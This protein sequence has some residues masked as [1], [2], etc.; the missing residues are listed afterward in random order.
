[1]NKRKEVV[2]EVKEIVDENDLKEESKNIDEIF[3]LITEALNSEDVVGE[4]IKVADSISMEELE[5]NTLKI[6]GANNE[7]INCY[8]DIDYISFLGP[9]EMLSKLSGDTAIIMKNNYIAWERVRET[10]LVRARICQFNSSVNGGQPFS[11]GITFPGSIKKMKCTSK[12]ICKA[13]I[14]AIPEGKTPINPL[15]SGT[16]EE[17]ELKEE[18]SRVYQVADVYSYI[19]RFI[20]CFNDL[21]RELHAEEEE[22]EEENDDDDEKIIGGEI[23]KLSKFEFSLYAIG[24]KQ[25]LFSNNEIK[26]LSEWKKKS[27]RLFSTVMCEVVDISNVRKVFV[28]LAFNYSPKNENFKIFT[29]NLGNQKL[30]KH[31]KFDNYG[32]GFIGGSSF[33]A[34]TGRDT[35]TG[36]ECNSYSNNLSDKIP[37]R[38]IKQYDNT[39]RL[40]IS[41][42]NNNIFSKENFEEPQKLIKKLKELLVVVNKMEN[43]NSSIR[44]EITYSNFKGKEVIKPLLVLKAIDKAIKEEEWPILAS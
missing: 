34:T 8:A 14:E 22:E 38:A 31:E 33:P 40:H 15:N 10:N 7:I 41:D 13:I 19:Q 1:M 11:I 6:D 42:G 44:V 35:A 43:I 24:Q 26:L 18:Q 2:N 23:F 12:I 39:K 21:F 20:K 9:I 25:L 37:A 28:D 32:L 36:I 3:D 17:F 5:K 29:S 27:K 4:L 30:K 16:K